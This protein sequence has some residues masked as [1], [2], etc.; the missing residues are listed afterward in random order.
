MLAIQNIKEVKQDLINLGFKLETYQEWEKKEEY[1]IWYEDEH[2]RKNQSPD[3]KIHCESGVLYI[4]MCSTYFQRGIPN[5]VKTLFT[6]PK[7]LIR[8]IPY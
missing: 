8:R 3:L 7:Y 4:P 1:L 2:P 5:I 6:D